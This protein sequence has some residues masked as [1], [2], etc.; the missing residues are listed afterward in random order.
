MEYEVVCKIFIREALDYIV[1]GKGGSRCMLVLHA[2]QLS[3][4]LVSCFQ[5]SIC[6]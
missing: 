6:G 3:N 5:D 1:Q 4:S 2:S